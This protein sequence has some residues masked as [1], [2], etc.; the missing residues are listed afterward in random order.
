M[1]LQGVLIKTEV[2]RNVSQWIVNLLISRHQRAMEDGPVG[3]F[4]E[5]SG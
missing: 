3:I 5:G 1:K 4:T 2:N